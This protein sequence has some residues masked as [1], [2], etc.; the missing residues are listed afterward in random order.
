MD[1][2]GILEVILEGLWR[3]SGWCS[4][5]ILEGVLDGFWR[6]FWRDSGGTLDWVLE[7]FWMD[8]GLGSEEILE[9]PHFQNLQKR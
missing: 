2:G 3:G 6:R 9:A 4:G 5:G 1:S 7:G 8:S